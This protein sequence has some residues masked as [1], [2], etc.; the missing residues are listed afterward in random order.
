MEKQRILSSAFNFDLPAER[1]AQRPRPY[2]EQKLLC[3]HRSEGII[4]HRRFQE[5]PS[6]LQSGD[7]LVAN[8]SSVVPAALRQS[9]EVFILFTDV[10]SP[11]L[12]DVKAICPSQPKIGDVLDFPN[13][14]ARFV[15]KDKE[16]LWDVYIGDIITDHGFATLL[17]FLQERGSHPI[18]NYIHRS[19][20]EQDV[21]SYQTTYA[22]NSGS[23]AC[24]VAGLHFND[25]LIGTLRQN[26]I[27]FVTA[28]LHVGYGTFRRFKSEFVDQ[29][30]ADKEHY[31]VPLSSLTEVRR[32]HQE[33]RR[34][35]AVGSTSARL[36]ETIHEF[37]TGDK[38]PARDLVGESEIFIAPP[39][40]FKVINGLITNLPYPRIPV[41]SMAAAFTGLDELHEIIRQALAN[42]YLFYSYGDA[43]LAL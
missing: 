27:L 35:I 19:P 26:G 17:E 16:P 22:K 28:T 37:V 25:E 18:P 5:L 32:A 23:I 7:L 30:Q 6:I 12:T 29:H 41:M 15:I 9:E 31:H 20:D 4:Q 36:L 10:F 43:I 21:Q 1:I 33:G 39:Y 14:R 40:K 2:D 24:P 42:D 3:F 8:D 38:D 11:S 34:I 13:A